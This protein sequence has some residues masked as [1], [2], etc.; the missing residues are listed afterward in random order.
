MKNAN[1]EEKLNR[2]AN[3]AAIAALRGSTGIG[4]KEKVSATMATGNQGVQVCFNLSL[5]SQKFPEA[6]T[7]NSSHQFE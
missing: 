2:E 1:Q 5:L 4:L 6:P 3:E 7:E